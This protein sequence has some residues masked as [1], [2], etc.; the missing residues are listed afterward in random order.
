MGGRSWNHATFSPQTNLLY[1]S[2][3]ELCN[4]I[5]VVDQ[6]PEPGASFFGGT[7]TMVPPPDGPLRGYISAHDPLTGKVAW[8]H[9]YKYFYFASLLSTRG[10]LI[11]VGDPEGNFIALD[12]RK[13]NKIWSYQ[14]GAGHR[15]SPM[16]YSV[17]G[18]QFVATSTGWGS[19]VG[20]IAGTLF[21]DMPPPRL[22]S[23]IVTFA[24]PKELKD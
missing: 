21:K 14:T 7:F 1:S 13:G 5:T 16:T 18:R 6:L 20:R 3:I 4:D 10:D 15:G 8:Q 23:A 11:F 24:L 2:G 12:A 9:D 17:E 19:L 22:G